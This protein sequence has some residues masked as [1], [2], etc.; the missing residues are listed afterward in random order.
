MKQPLKVVYYVLDYKPHS[1]EGQCH[2]PKSHFKL[3]SM[4]FLDCFFLLCG[5]RVWIWS[6]SFSHLPC[7]TE[8]KSETDDPVE[9]RKKRVHSV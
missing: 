2:Y 8:T 7:K 5:R 4:T 9:D 6:W 1:D 3:N